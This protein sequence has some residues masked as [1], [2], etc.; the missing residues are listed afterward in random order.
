MHTNQ[1]WLFFAILI[2]CLVAIPVSII[3][4]GRRSAQEESE[5]TSS[6]KDC[7]SSY[8]GYD[9]IS[10][11]RLTGLIAGEEDGSSIFSRR[12]SAGAVLKQ[13]RKAVKNTHVKGVLFRITSPGGTVSTSQEIADEIKALQAKKKPVVVS[14]GDV[15]AS[16]GY[17]VACNADKIVAE[18]GT[19][20]RKSVV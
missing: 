4:A 18:P 10:V 11:I 7:L 9:H 19:I 2:V 16:G 15:A 1:R 20:D 17:Y 3:G 6:D 14:M 5:S 8:I 13:L 12:E